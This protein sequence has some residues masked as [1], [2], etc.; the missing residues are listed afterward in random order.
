MKINEGTVGYDIEFFLADNEG[1]L[2]VPPEH[3]SQMYADGFTLI[4]DGL[5]YEWNMPPSVPVKEVMDTIERHIKELGYTPLGTS[6]ITTPKEYQTHP[7]YLE[8][9]CRPHRIVCPDVI[10]EVLVDYNKT[11]QR[12]SGFHIHWSHPEFR[13]NNRVIRAMME[14]W[15]MSEVYTPLRK[16]MPREFVQ[17]APL[18]PPRAFRKTRYAE[19][20]VAGIEFRGLPS[21]VFLSPAT[22][23]KAVNTLTTALQSTYEV[24]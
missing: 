24:M 9:G 11:T 6:V 2:V 14:D 21:D 1:K 13:H 12:A 22:K 16:L 5:A 7:G 17:R 18:I 3:Y 8:I 19:G 15:F 4:G 10:K 20:V 23:E